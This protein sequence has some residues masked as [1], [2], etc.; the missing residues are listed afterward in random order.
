MDIIN[1]TEICALNLEKENQ[2]ENAE[3]LR[4]K[5]SN[6]ISKNIHFKIR[7]NLSFEQRAALKELSQS[8]VKKVYS[9]DKGTSF[10]IL[11]NKDAI[12]KIE[13]QIGESIVSNKNTLQLSVN[14]KSLKLELIS[15]FIHRNPT[16]PHY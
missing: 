13:E 5:I 3:L 15:N 2:I 7:S 1:A 14:N 16:W 4:Q 9:Y 6:V 8:N 11:S 12:Q 10:V